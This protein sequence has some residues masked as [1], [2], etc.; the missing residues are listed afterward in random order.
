MRR[1][2]VVKRRKPGWGLLKLPIPMLNEFRRTKAA[3]KIKKIL[4]VM[5]RLSIGLLHR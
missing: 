2:L 4:L 5:F 1:I 3:S